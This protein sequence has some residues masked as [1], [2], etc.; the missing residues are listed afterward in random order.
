VFLLL[1]HHVLRSDTALEAA[2][3]GSVTVVDE[4]ESLVRDRGVRLI[5]FQDDDFLVGAQCP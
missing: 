3:V 4:V 2:A 5:L 1:D